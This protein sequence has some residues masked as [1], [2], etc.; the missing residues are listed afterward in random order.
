MLCST[1]SCRTL[2]SRALVQSKDKPRYKVGGKELTSSPLDIDH[3]VT[4]QNLSI[5]F[6]RYEFASM[7]HILQSQHSGLENSICL[8]LRLSPHQKPEDRTILHLGSF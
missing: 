5:S 3:G 1:R 2:A 6:A 4:Q 7:Y 8:L